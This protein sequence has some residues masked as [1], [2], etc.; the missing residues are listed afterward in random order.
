MDYVYVIQQNKNQKNL[1]MIN[2]GIDK[3]L[4]KMRMNQKKKLV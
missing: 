4:S 1:P 2:S 3:K